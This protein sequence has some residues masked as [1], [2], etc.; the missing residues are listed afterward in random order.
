M[1]M[2]S[3]MQVASICILFLDFTVTV[4]SYFLYEQR[5]KA[6]ADIRTCGRL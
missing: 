5:I 3:L 4:Q 2:R 6:Y 1:Q